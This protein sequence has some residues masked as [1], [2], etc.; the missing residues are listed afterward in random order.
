[1]QCNAVI[2]SAD[3]Y[4][5]RSNP[6]TFKMLQ[7]QSMPGMA[8]VHITRF[9]LQAHQAI[10]SSDAGKRG[11]RGVCCSAGSRP[12][13]NGRTGRPQGLAGVLVTVLQIKSS[14]LLMNVTAYT[15]MP[16]VMSYAEWRF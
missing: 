7:K 1:M 9:V 6:T 2:R 3:E 13:G 8:P 15:L 4:A 12:D 5:T 10:H 11:Q 14:N 16:C